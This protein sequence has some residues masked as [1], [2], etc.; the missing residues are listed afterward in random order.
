MDLCSLN[1]VLPLRHLGISALESLTNCRLL[2]CVTQI[3][4]QQGGEAGGWGSPVLQQ[5]GAG[6]MTSSY[7]EG[8]D[9]AEKGSRWSLLDRTGLLPPVAVLVDAVRVVGL[10]GLV[11]IAR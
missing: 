3:W 9:L 7:S 10:S 4:G 1:G 6:C 8:S 11:C 2:L 5:R